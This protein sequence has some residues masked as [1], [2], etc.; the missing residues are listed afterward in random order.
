LK[1]AAPPRCSLQPPHPARR[2]TIDSTAREAKTRETAMRR[3]RRSREGCSRR[4]AARP[5]RAAPQER[6]RWPSRARWRSAPESLL[7]PQQCAVRAPP[8]HGE[9]RD[10]GG[11]TKRGDA[12]GPIALVEC[13]HPP[14][15]QRVQ[16][17]RV[18]VLV[19]LIPGEG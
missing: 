13:H 11:G 6:I 7:S 16:R 3:T 14:P 18:G 10:R 15:G 2:S 12:C 8:Y 19:P 17:A 5:D 1:A 9:A 4:E